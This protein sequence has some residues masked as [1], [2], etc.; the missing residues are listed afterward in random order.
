MFLESRQEN[1]CDKC[2]C[3]ERRRLKVRVVVVVVVVVVGVVVVG[4]VVTAVVIT[5][6]PFL[7]PEKGLFMSDSFSI[8]VS[9]H[10]SPY[11]IPFLW[12]IRDF[13]RVFNLLIPEEHH[14]VSPPFDLLAAL[15]PKTNLS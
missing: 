15:S 1:I 2:E 6:P 5:F 7:P 8:W 4:V 3:D 13:P 11:H 10:D 14:P 12:A 9:S